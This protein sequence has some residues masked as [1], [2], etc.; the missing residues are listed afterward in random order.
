L[1]W[2]VE[3]DRSIVFVLD[4]DQDRDELVRQCLNIGYERLAGELAGGMD[5][6]ASRRLPLATV[7]LVD[8]GGVGGTLVDVRQRN[9]FESG[10]VPGSV[11]VELGS[12]AAAAAAL[13]E[14]PLTV[15]CGHG[16]RA[17]TAASILL[18]GGRADVFVVVG[19]PAEVASARRQ[20]LAG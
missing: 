15:M 4:S 7:G 19:G 10:H 16:E 1:G 6:W 13:P 18:A 8:P 14:G 11:N 12:A 9:E 3:R 20:Q 17:M 2:L 5:A